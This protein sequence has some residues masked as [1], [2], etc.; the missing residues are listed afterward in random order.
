MKKRI[1][2]KTISES[3]DSDKL[4][5]FHA[6]SLE[7]EIRFYFDD[8]RY[9]SAKDNHDG[10]LSI[11]YGEK[12][13]TN[14]IQNNKSTLTIIKENLKDFL[15]IMF[16]L[17]I[18]TL[19]ITF[20]FV[21]LAIIIKNTLIYLLII[22]F[23]YFFFGIVSVA[24]EEYKTTPPSLKSKHSA[25]HMM[26]NFLEKNK[27]LPTN[28][29]EI[30]E[31]TRFCIDC[32]SRELIRGYTEDFIQS[33]VTSILA[34][35][36]ASCITQNCENGIILGIIFFIFYI[37]IAYFVGILMRKYGKLDFLIEPIQDLLNN[38][39]QC[40]NTTKNVKDED[41]ILAYYAA[42]YWMKIVYPEFYVEDEDNFNECEGS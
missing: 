32:G 36:I 6:S 39:I 42:K 15:K 24:I 38:I 5:V 12:D 26:A 28:M 20:L 7:D 14:Y 35:V 40:C 21:I 9:V 17:S 30:K 34:V 4:I 13:T 41:I 29:D 8:K 10:T 25:E 3:N 11:Q 1:K 23:I 27:R 16:F 22:N 37:T 2:V 18:V 31:T 19:L 33:G